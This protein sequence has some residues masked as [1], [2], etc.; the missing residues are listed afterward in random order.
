M[1]FYHG[2][3]S[4]FET[5]KENSYITP[6]RAI[7]ATFGSILYE[8]EATPDQDEIEVIKGRRYFTGVKMGTCGPLNTHCDEG[9]QYSLTRVELTVRRVA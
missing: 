4:E 6:D 2:S 1:T 3:D 5:L 9:W 7:A 8:V